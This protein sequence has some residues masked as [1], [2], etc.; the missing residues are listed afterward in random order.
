[1]AWAEYTSTGKSVKVEC[2]LLKKMNKLGKTARSLL[3]DALARALASAA[4]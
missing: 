3:S 4:G 2:C 1:M